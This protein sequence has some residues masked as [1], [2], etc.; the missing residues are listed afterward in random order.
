MA[1]KITN[2]E[3]EKGRKGGREEKNVMQLVWGRVVPSVGTE[4]DRMNSSVIYLVDHKY[5]C[6]C[7]NAPPAQ[8]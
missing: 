5:L 1:K 2:A 7:Y 6:K 4:Q 8:Q 3:K